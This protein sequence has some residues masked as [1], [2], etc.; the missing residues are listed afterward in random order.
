MKLVKITQ[1]ICYIFQQLKPIRLVTQS[2]ESM[3]LLNTV[4]MAS[5]CHWLLLGE[6]ASERQ[7]NVVEH[8]A[9]TSPAVQSSHHCSAWCRE[10]PAERWQ[11]TATLALSPTQITHRLIFAVFQ[12]FAAAGPQV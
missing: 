1:K 11:Q 8:P 3:K 9:G 10:Q 4:M 7:R 12:H 6:P 2:S 5:T